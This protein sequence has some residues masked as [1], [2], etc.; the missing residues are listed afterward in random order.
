MYQITIIKKLES[1]FFQ[2]HYPLI[3][4]NARLTTFQQSILLSLGAHPLTK[5]GI[6]RILIRK[7]TVSVIF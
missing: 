3:A 7:I 5:L 1:K 4:D 2:L 6:L